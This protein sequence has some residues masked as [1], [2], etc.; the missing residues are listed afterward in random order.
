[1]A[2]NGVD[3]FIEAHGCMCSITAGERNLQ[4]SETSAKLPEEVESIMKANIVLIERNNSMAK[5]LEH[6]SVTEYHDLHKR[7]ARKSWCE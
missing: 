5:E 1:M 3:N 7:K 2:S 6:A 4:Q